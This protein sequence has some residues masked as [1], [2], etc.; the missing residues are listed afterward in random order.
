MKLYDN[1]T[2]T[3]ATDSRNEETHCGCEPGEIQ[4]LVITHIS[5]PEFKNTIRS[6]NILSWDDR[7]LSEQSVLIRIK[8]R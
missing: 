4:H 3:E 1:K 5:I 2:V 8:Y 7:V 6:T